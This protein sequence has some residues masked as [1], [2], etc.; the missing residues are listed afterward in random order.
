MTAVG[1]A[2]GEVEVR[3]A[4]PENMDMVLEKFRTIGIRCVPNEDGVLVT[5]D[6][7]LASVDISTLPYPGVATDYKPFLV[8]LLA[9]ADGVSIVSEN[10]FAGRFRYVDELRRMGANITIEGHH[11]VI[12]GVPRLSGA[13][14]RAPDIRGGAALALAGLV[15]EGQ[16]EIGAWGHITRGYEDFDGRLRAL[17]ADIVPLGDEP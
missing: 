3:G 16:T 17:G 4:R 6:G 8:T 14:V 15:A 13:Q 5:S 1:L 7:S 12:R 10:L 11:A 9:V 2:G